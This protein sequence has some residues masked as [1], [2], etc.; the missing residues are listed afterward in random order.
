MGQQRPL[1]MEEFE[2]RPLFPF[3]LSEPGDIR[4]TF[5]TSSGSTLQPSGTC[6]PS[7]SEHLSAASL[8]LEPFVGITKHGGHYSRRESDFYL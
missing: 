3:E 8:Q 7:S 4:L 5:V 2:S 6:R 1:P